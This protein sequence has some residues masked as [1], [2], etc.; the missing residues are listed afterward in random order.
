M[1]LEEEF[2]GHKR[3]LFINND[4]KDLHIVSL[5]QDGNGHPVLLRTKDG[6][7][8]NWTNVISLVDN[9]LFESKR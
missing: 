4:I 9:P 7:F 1:D 2:V 6:A 8:W 5:I 3:L